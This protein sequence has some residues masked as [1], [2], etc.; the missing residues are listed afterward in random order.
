[1]FLQWRMRYK[2]G[3]TDQDALDEE[4]GRLAVFSSSGGCRTVA[5]ERLDAAELGRRKRKLVLFREMSAS[6]KEE[7]DKK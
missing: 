7:E 3:K 4:L 5:G 6:L 2:G 1:M